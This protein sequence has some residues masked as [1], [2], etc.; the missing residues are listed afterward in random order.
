VLYDW[1]RADQR[2]AAARAPAGVFFDET[3]RDGVQAPEIANPT[4][5]QRYQLIEHMVRCGIRCADLG[6]PGSGP[7][8]AH[9]CLATARYVAA[10]GHPLVPGYAGRTHPADVRAICEIAQRAG[11]AVDAY[12]F[13]GVSPI[14]QYVEG[15][16]ISSIAHDIRVAASRC[17]RDGVD[18]VLVLEDSARC[19]PGVLA[20]VYD[21]AVDLGIARIT[22]CDTV[23]AASPAGTDALIRWSTRYFADRQH[24]VALEW[25]GHNDR[26]LGLVNSLTA[27]AAG[28]ARIH[29][30]VLGIGERAGNSSIDQ[31]IVNSQLE[32][33]GDYDLKALRE[34]C[35]FASGVLGFAIPPNYPAM[36][37]D[38]FK[39]S[40]GVHASAILKAHQK[41]D[42]SVKD[43]VYS[44]VPASLLGREQE[45]LI[46]GSSGAS[47]VRYWLSVNGVNGGVD[48][49]VVED[50]LRKAR[51]AGRPLTDEE[52]RRVLVPG[53]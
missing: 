34:Y 12:V 48:G 38:V 51:R 21:L 16:S 3:L 32:Y 29:G 50:V 23:G 14:R 22:L 9:A 4:I 39:T 52:I 25:H 28:C 37:R 24:P 35:E 5:E 40:A 6:F 26:G 53:R 7:A 17:R 47:N 19:T 20:T 36:G 44:G 45:V 11:I 18:F 10:Q 13:I 49:D 30:T 31:L 41:G 1:S 42:L 2:H 46:D 8:A 33:A 43:S 27:L 15:W